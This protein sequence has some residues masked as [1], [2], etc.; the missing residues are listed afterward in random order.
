MKNLFNKSF[1]NKKVIITGH[2][3][4]KGSWLSVWLK[5]LGANVIGISLNTITKP[6]HFVEANISKGMEDIR[7]D[8]KN[9]KK[10][11]EAINDH[12]P[13]FIFHLAAQAI[14]KESYEDPLNTWETNVIGSLNVLD[15]L[16]KLNK[17]C[18]VVMITSD[19]CYENVEWLWGYKE[20]DTLGGA[21]PYSASK[22]AT[23]I[24]ISSYIRSFF[25]P[26]GKIKIATARAGNVIGGGDWAANRIVPDIIKAWSSD[27]VV[28]LRYPES[29]RPWQHVLEPL[30]GYLNLAALLNKNNNLHGEAFNFGPSDS[31]NYSVQNLVESM[32]NH[33]KKSK[34]KIVKDNNKHHEAGL[35]KLNCDKSLSLLEW[36]S[37]MNFD[38]TVKFTIDWYINY[39][40]KNTN[41]IKTTEF[42]IKNYMKLANER[43]IKWSL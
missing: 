1:I 22:A 41:S 29:T 15:S 5:L 37:V 33:W 21:D 30:S 4:F 32:S 13:D 23:E 25:K 31:Q 19:K 9:K 3:G 35:L 43:K 40:G 39:Y 11:S 42:Q 38:E 10:L 26:D 14:V 12:K 7:I 36:K 2:T 8:I 34:W 20:I 27:E 18:S 28:K 6:S 17:K 16:K 24:G